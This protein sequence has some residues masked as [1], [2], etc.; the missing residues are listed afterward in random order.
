MTL[1]ENLQNLRRAGGLSQEE[2]AQKL[3]VS[4]Q[5]VSKWENDQAEP[6]VENLKTLARLYGVSVDVLVG[7]EETL[8]KAPVPSDGAFRKLLKY[9]VALVAVVLLC[10]LVAD[11][12]SFLL[13]LLS[14]CLAPGA[15]F[16]LLCYWSKQKWLWIL[17]MGTES[18]FVMIISV[19][20]GTEAP[21]MGLMA[22]LLGGAWLFR[23]CQRDVQ[24]L[25]YKEDEIP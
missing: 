5:S 7:A 3:F 14:E 19:V 4:R 1:G 13:L 25:F 23:L 22:L 9:R 11:D 6:G 20:L 21:F 8:E 2:V 15:F 18:I 12:W 10:M 16:M 17:L 24:G